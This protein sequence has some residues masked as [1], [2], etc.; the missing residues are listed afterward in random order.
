MYFWLNKCSLKQDT[1]TLTPDFWT[2]VYMENFFNTVYKA[3]QDA[4]QYVY[5]EKVFL[6]YQIIAIHPIVLLH[7]SGDL[8]INLT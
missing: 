7:N 6:G 5:W 1:K 4:P 8:T 3:S 2:V